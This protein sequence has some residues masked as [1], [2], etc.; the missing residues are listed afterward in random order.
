MKAL[1]VLIAA[2]ALSGCVSGFG[3]HHPKW[4]EA[5]KTRYINGGSP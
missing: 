3:A 1:I 4:T 2:M 5:Q